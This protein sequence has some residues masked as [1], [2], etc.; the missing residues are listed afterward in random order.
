[1]HPFA[2][3]RQDL[4]KSEWPGRGSTGPGLSLF[5]CRRGTDGL[6]LPRLPSPSLWAGNLRFPKDTAVPK[7]ALQECPQARG[8]AVPGC[9]GRFHLCSHSPLSNGTLTRVQDR[10]FDILC[11]LIA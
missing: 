7:P 10:T 11:Y 5:G 6:P 4:P 1:M 2:G 3:Q 9:A 8:P